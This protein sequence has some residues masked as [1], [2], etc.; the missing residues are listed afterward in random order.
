MANYTG[1]KVKLSRRVGVPIA[2]IPKHTSKRQLNTLVFIAR[3][4]PVAPG[5]LARRLSMEKSTLSRNLDRMRRQGWIGVGP[6]DT[7]NSRSVVLRAKGRRI[8]ERARPLWRD[9]QCRAEEM[10]GDRGMRSV[11]R[12]VD[13][14][15]SSGLRH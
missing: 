14:V 12:A 9:A 15:V 10:L 4:G 3:E 2:D 5:A 8:I 7:G 11:R 1:P 6:G 13:A